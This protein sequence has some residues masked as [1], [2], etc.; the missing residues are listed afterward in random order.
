MEARHDKLYAMQI[1]HI[2][3]SKEP[4][5]KLVDSVR[6]VEGHCGQGIEMLQG[7]AAN[8]KKLP[9]QRE[10]STWQLELKEPLTTSSPLARRISVNQS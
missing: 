4:I 5:N 10:T 6:S 3:A 7:S 2:R 1:A 9:F 8:M